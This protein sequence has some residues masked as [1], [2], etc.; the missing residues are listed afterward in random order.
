[1]AFS[2]SVS[3]VPSPFF[4]RRR[5]FLLPVL[6][7]ISLPSSMTM[8]FE[9]I[10]VSSILSLVTS[11]ASLVSVRFFISVLS[12]M[13][14]GSSSGTGTTLFFFNRRRFFL[15]FVVSFSSI[16]SLSFVSLLGAVVEFAALAFD[17]S[18]FDTSSSSSST[19]SFCI[20]ERNFRR[21]LEWTT[22]SSSLYGANFFKETYCFNVV[23]R[24]HNISIVDNP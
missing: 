11:V 10:S 13:S 14:F 3:A 23:S 16:S 24:A 9:V 22:Y 12:S 21:L 19:I 18:V 20:N 7:L 15:F 5:R 17:A 6:E 8:L 1:M 4:L 2:V